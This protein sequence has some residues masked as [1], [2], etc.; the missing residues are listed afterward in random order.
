MGNG[1]GWHFQTSHRMLT[2]AHWPALREGCM[3][4]RWQWRAVV[5]TGPVVIGLDETMARR[6]GAQLAAQGMS[7][8]PGRS[9]PA[10]FVKASGWRWVGLRRR[11][12]VPWTTRV[13]GGLA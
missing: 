10:P 3:L 7:R 5:P 1:A 11:A 13:W 2:R 4:L 12:P 8:D 9:S 6:R